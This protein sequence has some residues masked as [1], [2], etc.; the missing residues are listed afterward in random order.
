[1]SCC[2]NSSKGGSIGDYSGE[3]YDHLRLILGVLEVLRGGDGGVLGAYPGLRDLGGPL[4]YHPAAYPGDV[5]EESIRPYFENSFNQTDLPGLR[6][7]LE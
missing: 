7:H 6:Q 2:L 3:Y 4:R 5:C 1:M